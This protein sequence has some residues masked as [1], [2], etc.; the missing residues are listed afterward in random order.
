MN[1]AGTKSDP[2][3]QVV[4]KGFVSGPLT[5]QQLKKTPYQVETGRFQ[6]LMQN[7]SP[8]AG[9]DPGKHGG[10]HWW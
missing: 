4:R 1:T 5:T 9:S 6:S 10:G 2:R 3:K 7:G 8:I